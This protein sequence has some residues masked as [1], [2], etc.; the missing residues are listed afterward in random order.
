MLWL[1][2]IKEKLFK[3]VFQEFKVLWIILKSEIG[4]CCIHCALI[5]DCI[6]VYSIRFSLDYY[7]W[8]C[9][10]SKIV[11]K[12]VLYFPEGGVYS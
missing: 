9:A 12:T 4:L 8:C 11:L 3:S 10:V 2:I 7:N 6:Q 5:F 1:L